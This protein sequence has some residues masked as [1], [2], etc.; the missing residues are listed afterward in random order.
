MQLGSGDGTILAE[1]EGDV[2]HTRG[3]LT[4]QTEPV[5]HVLLAMEAAIGLLASQ[6]SGVDEGVGLRSPRRTRPS[7]L[8]SPSGTAIARTDIIGPPRCENA[9]RK[10]WRL[11]PNMPY[12][13]KVCH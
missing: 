6:A 12:W 10:P 4:A 7:S 9:P 8:T 11:L 5:P 2:E 1:A 13:H 3:D